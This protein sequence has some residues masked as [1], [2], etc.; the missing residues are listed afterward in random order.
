[1]LLIDDS[2]PRDWSRGPARLRV[3]DSPAFAVFLYDQG[4]LD[5]VQTTMALAQSQAAHRVVREASM[6]LAE[7][8]GGGEEKSP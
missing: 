4:R 7:L 3:V 1:V 2:A 6:L 5:Y 8:A